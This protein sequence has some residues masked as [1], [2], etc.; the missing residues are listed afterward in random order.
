MLSQDFICDF[1]SVDVEISSKDLDFN[2]ANTG[3]LGH[4]LGQK[5]GIS[6]VWGLVEWHFLPQVRCQESVG[7]GDGGV[8]SLSEVTQGGGGSAALGV[9]I[10]DTSHL[11]QLLG[12][13]SANDACSTWSWDQLDKD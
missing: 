9:A 7:F 12:N 8:G 5:V 13:W 11:Q 1:A 6:F 10:F 3:R 4:G 2:V